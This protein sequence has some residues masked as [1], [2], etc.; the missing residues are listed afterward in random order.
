MIRYVFQNHLDF[1]L[2]MT[3][4]GCLIIISLLL[5]PQNNRT[6]W[7]RIDKWLILFPKFD[8]QVSLTKYVSVKWNWKIVIIWFTR[9]N[10]LE[11]NTLSALNNQRT[12]H[13]S[14]HRKLK[15]YIKSQMKWRYGFPL[16]WLNIGFKKKPHPWRHWDSDPR[17]VWLSKMKPECLVF[18]QQESGSNGKAFQLQESGRFDPD[19]WKMS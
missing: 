7:F 6:Y 12:L 5:Y 4:G 10:Q 8:Q 15:T 16:K 19:C 2:W 3:K 14:L 13:K 11:N 9:T 17:F 1:L 18:K